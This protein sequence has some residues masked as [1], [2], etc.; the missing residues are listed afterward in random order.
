MID[1]D[2]SGPPYH[3]FRR[4]ALVAIL[5][6]VFLLFSFIAGLTYYHSYTNAPYPQSLSGED[7]SVIVT[8]PKGSSVKRIGEILDDSGVIRYDFRFLM[9]ARLSGYAKSLR[10]GEFEMPLGKRPG[11]ILQLLTV[12][13]PVTYPVT[14]P[15]GLT[16]AE[17]GARFASEGWC[18]EEKFL[19]LVHDPATIEGFGLTSLNSLEGF[20][21]PDTYLL[22]KETRGAEKI[23]A[24]LLGRFKEVW[25]EET[26]TIEPKPDVDRTVILASIVEKETADPS[27]RPLIAGVFHNRLKR[28]MRLQ[29]DPTV[30]YGA[31]DYNGTITRTHLRTPTPYNTYTL[32]GLPI[33]PIANP[34]RES[35]VAVLH[36]QQ[37]SNL[38][39]V[40]KNDGTHQFSATLAAHNRAVQ[41]YQRKKKQKKGNK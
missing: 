28:G 31:L 3:L 21:F 36:P 11:E 4:I 23:I 5:L 40:S 25:Q 19:S 6:F 39:F 16:A 9:L 27:E 32:P 34:G 1:P 33:G 7:K 2:S 38:Y 26:A 15:E 24:L 22:T 20:L 17:I 30:V 37:S 8:I 12:A 18:E 41:K 35:L 14:I 29:S 13:R 10:A